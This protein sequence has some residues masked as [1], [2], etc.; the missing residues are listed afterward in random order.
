[1]SAQKVM[2]YYCTKHTVSEMISHIFLQADLE[3]HN[4]FKITV[5]VYKVDTLAFKKNY[6]S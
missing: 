2:P 4:N 6:D 1:M 5:N 3:Q